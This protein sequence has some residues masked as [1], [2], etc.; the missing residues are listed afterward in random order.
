MDI[1][2][3]Y[4]NHEHG[5]GLFA[6]KSMPSRIKCANIGA[7]PESGPHLMRS[8]SI[9]MGHSH[10]RQL[11]QEQ[12]DQLTSIAPLSYYTHFRWK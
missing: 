1:P 2:I 3:C 12:Y 5:N 7:K 4:L 11:P 10:I 8:S 9:A 6:T